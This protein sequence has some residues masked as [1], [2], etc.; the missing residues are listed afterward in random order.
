[1]EKYKDDL[2][3]EF[4]DL[5]SLSALLNL[6]RK[7][8]RRHLRDK[9]LLSVRQGQRRFIFKDDI[10][11][12]YPEITPSMLERDIRDIDRDITDKKTDIRDTKGTFEYNEDVPNVPNVP[13]VPQGSDAI[14]LYKS[15]QKQDLLIRQVEQVK[16]VVSRLEKS[17]A[18]IGYIQKDTKAIDRKLDRLNEKDTERDKDIKDIRDIL[19]KRGR[20]AGTLVGFLILGLIV[21]GLIG[22]GAFGVIKFKE[23][24]Q[25]TRAGYEE[26]L[27]TK[28]AQ[29]GNITENYNRTLIEHTKEV[30]EK[31]IE[32]ESLRNTNE[33]LGKTIEELQETKRGR[34]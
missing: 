11:R 12:E 19:K 21:L 32:I 24:Y 15:D 17:I 34:R 9:R 26:T 8:V 25:K 6:S 16:S 14:S 7:Q 29:I 20:Q 30:G 10:L 23:F 33:Q 28:D 1:M 13:D 22:A 4:I 31:G 3:R 5:S 18:D 2:G 27:R